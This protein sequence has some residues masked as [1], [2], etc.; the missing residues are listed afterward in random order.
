MYQQRRFISQYF[1]LGFTL[2][3]PFAMQAG[4]LSI[5]S[6]C[7]VGDCTAVDSLDNNQSTDGG[8]NIDYTFLDG[9]TYNISGTFS[10][11]YSTIG[12]ST[13]S[14][15]PVINYLGVAPTVGTDTLNLSFLQNYFD[16]T[17][18]TWAGTYTESVPLV[19]NGNFGPGS[20]MSAEL[21]YDGVGVGPVGPLA[22]PGSYFVS[23]SSNLDFGAGDTADTLSADYEFHF[24]FGAGTMPGASQTGVTPEPAPMM[25]CGLGLLLLGSAMRRRSRP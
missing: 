5:N 15:D 18:C 17:C 21:F 22:A 19:A 3:A 1:V 9:D 23:Q 8:F 13:I 2:L 14:I 25:L 16:P 24:I 10:A 12:G 11:S 7:Y 4:A 20:Q 6:T